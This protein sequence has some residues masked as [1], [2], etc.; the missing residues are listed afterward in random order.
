MVHVAIHPSQFP[1]R[2]R[3]ALVESLRTRRVNHKFHYDSVKQTAQW[4]ALHE[5]CSPSRT[6]PDCAAIYERS[7]AAAAARMG[8]K[9]GRLHVVGLGCGGGRKDT[10]LLELLRGAGAA[11]SYTPADVSVAMALAA[12]Q[13]ALAAVPGL[14]C[15]PLVCDFAAA[16]DLP[17]VIDGLSP[18][19]VAR[20]VTFFGMIPNFEP[21]TI[22]PRLAGVTRPG[23]ALL[24]SAN[25]APGADYAEGVKSILPQYDNTLTRDWLLTFLLDLGVSREDGVM[26][27]GVA[28]DPAGSGLKRVEA[29][30]DFLRRREVRVDAERFVFEPGE[31]IR[32][33]YSYRYTPARARALL[34]AHGLEVLG[35][36]I[37]RSGEEAV[38]LAV[39]R[40]ADS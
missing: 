19:K 37:T 27:F 30:F 22:L 3:A 21:G 33:F 26:R 25:L 17:E 18:P 9:A 40:V 28:D 15:N 20:I 29:S 32:L 4:L 13:T 7:F 6:D 36:W 5:A 34:G 11:V 39:P 1:D 16:E 2:V 10:R 35:E 23:D 12:R 8:A 14:R 31:S 38:F 24:F